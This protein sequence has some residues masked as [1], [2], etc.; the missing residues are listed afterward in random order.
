M[1]STMTVPR[2]ISLRGVAVHNLK[3]VDLDLP[4]GKW[5]T[6]CGVSGSG[7]SSLAFDTLYA[8][9]Q[10]R[11][12]ESFSPSARQFWQRLER[13]QVTRIDGLRP[14]VAI[15]QHQAPPHGRATVGT[16]TELNDYL[17]LL[18]AKLGRL[19]CPTCEVEVRPDS[20][21][22]IAR[23]LDT[24][25]PR[26]RFQLAFP[27]PI[28]AE[29]DLSEVAEK[30]R[31][32][33]FQRA[34]WEEQTRELSSP[35]PW[36]PGPAGA[37]LEVVVDRLTTGG[38]PARLLDSL[39]TAF[40]QGRG[41]AIL[42]LEDGAI[43]TPPP[44]EFFLRAESRTV[45][46]KLWQRLVCRK[47]P[48]CPRC[49][50]DFP[51]PEPALFHF[52][53]PLGACPRCEGL[54][55][56]ED[57]EWERIVPDPRKSLAAGAVIPWTTSPYDSE[58]PKILRAA[59]AAGLP[60]RA[61]LGSWS[62][63]DRAAL[64]NGVPASGFAGLCSF[65]SELSARKPTAAVRAYLA[66]F[67]GELLCPAC[68]GG[69]LRP[70][71]LAYRLSGKNFVEIVHQ[72]V[73]ELR[74]W[75]AS[76]TWGPGQDT[77]AKLPG[78]QV[79]ARL[80][81]LQEVGLGYLTLDRPLHTLSGGEFQRVALTRAL[82]SSLV[83]ALYVLDEPSLGL[84]P[85]D[86]ERLV[87]AIRRLRD[88]GNTVIVVEHEEALLRAADQI[89]E[90]GPGAG[91]QG[92]KVVFQGTLPEMLVAPQSVTGDFLS[93][94]RGR[95]ALKR[96]PQSHGWLQLRGARG[97]NLQRIDVDIPLG[98]L[99]VVTGVSGA[100]KSTLVQDTLYPA[101]CRGLGRDTVPPA[102]HDELLGIGQLGDCLLVDPS[103]LGRSPRSNP[104]TYL[105]AFEEIRSVFADT[106][107]ARTRNYG[108]SHFSFNAEAGRC[109]TCEGDGL[110]Q[111]DMQFL[112]DV[113]L[114]CPDCQ[115]TRYRRDILVVTYRGKNI[116]EVLD[117]TVREAFGF[118]R[119][120]PKVQ[121]KLKPLLDVGLDY[122]R[123][124]QP[125]PSLSG[126]E[127]QRLKLAS[128]L[129]ETR[130]PRTLFVL[131]EPTTGLHF[132]DVVQLLDCFDALLAVGHSLLVVEHNLQ[133]I[134]AADYLI[135]LGP[136]PAEQGGR[137]VAHGTPEQVAA[138]PD[139]CTGQYLRRAL[140]EIAP[141]SSES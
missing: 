9:G 2:P 82:G 97:H 68:Q 83:D 5:I 136:G 78:A 115:G 79:L 84:H 61:P 62:E 50:R 51:P 96:R 85:H 52:H 131:D 88:R 138:H 66:R 7:K 64:L 134:R 128:C 49:Q 48:R 102:P 122:L 39:E 57:W 1:I 45:D 91:D 11:F 35:G 24:L 67:R 124:G 130:R 75:F 77:L 117:F 99:C 65:F 40:A 63:R 133:L 90:I 14:A 54:G 6:F 46:K 101:V 29:D 74:A 42:Y 22:S 47:S 53:S 73:E 3:Q 94:R 26:L 106:P 95:H 80:R 121:K 135:D 98:S 114:P 140:Q 43:S 32:Q 27:V 34:I 72:K 141:E 119:G 37:T 112:P 109:G 120:F 8:E 33:G 118:F 23:A 13:P 87:L 111:I 104:V 12:L 81:Y 116:A 103:P 17:R 76:L 60:T 41:R 139:S 20:P 56:V 28:F 25:P 16:A 21:P 55:T 58:F 30:L 18:C 38:P 10:R 69:R 113:F 93:G 108:A 105:K 71:S 19:V 132:R 44:E 137:V 31:E 123:L 15:A 86:T 59:E 36:P 129:A 126:G 70:E 89:V 107:E 110:R 4:A 92:G 125:A 100:G 127:A